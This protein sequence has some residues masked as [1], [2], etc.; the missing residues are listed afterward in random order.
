MCVGGRG[1]EERERVHEG[2][3]WGEEE[4]EECW[5]EKVCWQL[6]N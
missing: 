2:G 6:E 1:R 5:R 4:E 3:G